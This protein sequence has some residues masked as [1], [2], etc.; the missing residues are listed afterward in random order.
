MSS[1]STIQRAASS[2][3]SIQAF[4]AYFQ[5]NDE[6]L[7]P[8]NQPLEIQNIT[9]LTNQEETPCEAN[10]LFP[11]DITNLAL[12]ILNKMVLPLGKTI[13]I[14]FSEPG[15]ICPDIKENFRLV[16]SKRMRLKAETGPICARLTD[17]FKFMI[18][19]SISQV[20]F[21]PHQKLIVLGIT[22]SEWP[23]APTALANL[24]KIIC[25]RVPPGFNV[26][27]TIN[28]KGDSSL[29]S[30]GWVTCY[31]IAKQRSYTIASSNAWTLTLSESTQFTFNVDSFRERMKI[32]DELKVP[33]YRLLIIEIANLAALKN[34]YD[35]AQFTAPSFGQFVLNQILLPL[36]KTVTIMFDQRVISDIRCGID[37]LQISSSA[38]FT[39]KAEFGDLYAN[40]TNL[41]EILISKHISSLIL[42]PHQRLFIYGLTDTQKRERDI[43]I[44]ANN[45]EM[46]KR[47]FFNIFT[48]CNPVGFDWSLRGDKN[49][50]ISA[51]TAGNHPNG[52][53]FVMGSSERLE[54]KLIRA[55]GEALVLNLINRSSPALL[56]GILAADHNASIFILFRALFYYCCEDFRHFRTEELPDFFKPTTQTKLIELLKQ[57]PDFIDALQR[58]G[59]SQEMLEQTS[60]ILG[61]TPEAFSKLDHDTLPAPLRLMMREIMKLLNEE[62]PGS[63]FIAISVQ[64]V[65]QGLMDGR[66]QVYLHQRVRERQFIEKLASLPAEPLLASEEKA[67]AQNPVQPASPEPAK[68][69]PSRSRSFLWSIVTPITRFLAWIFRR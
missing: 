10:E 69:I 6:L 53:M 60:T 51:C 38:E 67:A 12:Y 27:T 63:R 5:E 40:I 39:L 25:P 34:D 11:R 8:A 58:V 42:Q 57:R 50:A 17:L 21:A 68:S 37:S 7:L 59:E 66:F 46:L 16:H 30:K 65:R 49:I 47:G 33:P 13:N 61:S 41:G 1:Q 20:K 52:D 14:V 26:G 64:I 55:D 54:L 23:L 48:P 56:Q 2:F 32:K 22:E 62:F 24:N 15:D 4:Q 3:Q 43:W 9:S 31:D 29:V 44:K 18:A 36:G 45:E 28:V 35:N 19:S